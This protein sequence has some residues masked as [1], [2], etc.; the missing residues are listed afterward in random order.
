MNRYKVSLEFLEPWRINHLGDDRG[1]AW[2]RWVQTREGYQRPE[3]TGTLVR[4]AVI[5]AAEELLALTGGVWAGQKCC[6]G[7]FCTPGG[8]KPTFRRQRATR[9]WGED[10]LCTPDSPC[11]FCQLL[12]RHDLAGKQARRGGGFHVHFGNLYPVAREGYGSLAEITR[13][14]TSNRLD[15]L[16]GKAQDILTICEVEELR[17]FS[18]L[19]TVAPELANGEAVSSLLTAAAA[20][21]DRLSGAACRLK[22]QPVEELWSGTAV[23]LTRAAVPE[24][25]YRQQLEEDIDNYFQELIG[26]GSQL[27]P[28]R[29]RLLADAIRELRYLPPEQ[30]LPDWLQSLPQGKDGKAHRL[31]DALTAQRRPLRN[32]LQE[33]A[34][35]Y[36]APATWRDVVQGLGQALYAHYKKLWPQAMPVRPVGEAEYWQTKF[37]DRQPSRQR[38]TWSHEWII[39]GALQTLTPLYLG[40]QVEAARQTSLTVLLTAEGRY[41]LPRTALRGALRQD[42]QLASRGQGCLMELNPERPCSCPICQIMRRLTVRDVTSSIALPP[43]LVRQRV[44]RNPWTGIVD[45]GALFD[46]EV[47]PEGLRFPFILRYRG[48]GGLD[49]W[50]QTVLSWWQEG[51]L[52]LGGAG[53]TGKG[54]LRLTDLRIWRWALDETGLPTYVAHL[55]YRGREEELANSASLPAGVEAVTCSDPATVPSPWQEV[56]WEFRFH[57]PVLANHPLTALLR[58]EADAVFTWKV[59][60][61]ADQQHYRE[62][63][64]LKGETVRGLVRGL[65]GKSQ[66]LLTKAHADCTCLLC[67]VFGNEHQRGKVRFE[68]LTLAG[69][70]VPK[71]RL[72]HVAI[73][74]ISGGAAEQLKFDTQPLYGTP[75]NPLVFAGKFWVHTELDEEEQKALRAALTALRDGLATVGAKGSVGYGWLNGLR[76]HSGPAWLTDNWQETAAAPSDTNTPPEFSW[77]QLPDLTLDSRKIYY[78]HYFLPPDLQVP[79]LSQPHT[80][81]LFDPQKYTGW[82]TCRLTTLTP[83]II[84]DTSSDQTLTT[85]GPFP[86]GHQAFQFFRLGDQPLIPGAELRGM[87][88]SVF[89]AI[90]NSCFRVIRPRERLS[91]RMP[92]ALAPQFRSGRVEIVNNQYY[93]RQMDMGRL[94]LYD[95]PATRRLFTPLSLTSGHTLDFVD[96]NRTLLQSN[97]GIREGAIRTDLCFLNRFWLLRPPSAARCPR[98]NFSLTSG[99]VKFTGPNKVEVSRAGAGAGGLP[100]PPADWT[101]V[102]LNQVAG[103]VPFYQAEQSGVIFTV[104]KRRERFFISRGNARSYPVPL[105]TLKRYEQVLKEYRHFAQRGEVPAVFRTVLPDVRHGAS[106]YNRLNNGDLVYFR[107]KDDRW[108]DQNAPVE[109]II[110]VSIS[111]LVDQKFLGERVPEPLRPCAHV[112]LEECEACLKQESCPSSFYREGTPS[113]GLC[114]AC[115]LFGT[116]GYQGRVRF[117]FARLEREPAWRQNDAGSTAITL[118]LLEQPRLTWSMLWE[119]R[120]AEGTVE[121]RQPVNWVPGRKFYVHHQGWRTIVAQGINPIDGQRL[122]RNENNRTVEVL[123]TG[124]TFTFQV[125]FENLDAWE[126][127][128]LLYSLELEPGLA[129]KL[130][131]AKA[132]G[133]GSVQIDVASLRRYQAPGSMT[134]ITCEKDTLLQAGFAW[135]KEQANSSSWDE[136]PR[137]RQLRQLLRYQEDGTLTVRYPILKQENAASGQVPGYVELRDQG[138]RP[139]EQLRIPWS[140]WYSPPLEPPPAATA[141]A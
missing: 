93:I 56:D 103:N 8:S 15:W 1:A 53:G 130:G 57:G 82:L 73:D 99:Y 37:R 43:P 67:R 50:L 125:F 123:D 61:E 58:G 31:W 23:S 79:R 66:G 117:G 70:T 122:E 59:Q 104:N 22:L 84:P 19:I 32:M 27:G 118:P 51:R 63:C 77:P 135:L 72:D 20:L 48:F 54:R 91:W 21:V 71:K 110:P 129:H 44:R 65:F 7:E 115:H 26:D 60:L 11:P 102:R 96:D 41:R 119:R 138:Y 126:L 78:P 52:F 85:G 55:G 112:C 95:D 80:H 29:L 6:P 38:G 39:T 127:G 35:A 74:R 75:E 128:L 89:E 113:R 131:M 24:T 134:D 25:A 136:I 140:P 3:I 64:T 98:G 88:S 34:A 2:A 141:A 101:G 30:T 105:A 18:G 108:N 45:E 107:V 62:V 33:V 76:L 42:L 124:R 36:A 17:R 114:P 86:A 106:G 16:T 46:Q 92:A 90:T 94:P 137:L 9:W 10:S 133:F 68:D 40:T 69:E 83:L 12:G 14:R 111:R 120:N 87:I 109:H 132:W 28:E 47:A 100:A 5:R 97:P 81:S 49:A 139:E 116:T 13:Q 4:S 121:E